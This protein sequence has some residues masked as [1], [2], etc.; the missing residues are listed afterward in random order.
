M[1]DSYE[2]VKWLLDHNFLLEM[3]MFFPR[4]LETLKLLYP[5]IK[6]SNWSIYSFI[7][8]GRYDFLDYIYECEGLKDRKVKSS[9]TV[10]QK[11]A[12]ERE[13]QIA[14]PNTIERW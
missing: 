8:K 13:I 10:F 3:T 4:N 2:K 6:I 14:D 5:G 11:W 12:K 1:K 7:K 9:C